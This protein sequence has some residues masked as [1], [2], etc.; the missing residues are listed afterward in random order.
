MAGLSLSII[1]EG[2]LLPSLPRTTGSGSGF[3]EE[4]IAL[5]LIVICVEVRLLE[6]PS[7]YSDT[8]PVTA[9]RSP[10]AGFNDELVL[11]T[12]IPSDVLGLSSG[13]MSCMKKPLYAPVAKV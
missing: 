8:V 3:P 11:Y 1:D 9:T 12:K 10:I 5:S 6:L 7:L 4:I 2:M 13:F